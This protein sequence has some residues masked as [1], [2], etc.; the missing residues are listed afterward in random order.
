MESNRG[1]SGCNPGDSIAGQSRL[2]SFGFW[3]FPGI[4]SLPLRS[5]SILLSPKFLLPLLVVA[6]GTYVAIFGFPLD[7]GEAWG[8]IATADPV[9]LGAAVLVHYASY[10]LRGARWRVLMGGS[11]VPVPGFL[12]CGQLILLGWFVNSVGWIRLG[13]PFR[14]HLC[15]REWG[16]SFSWVMGTIVAER[17]LDGLLVSLFLLSAGLL[18]LLSGQWDVGA[19]ALGLSLFLLLVLAMALVLMPLVRWMVRRFLPARGF[20]EFLLSTLLRFRSGFAGGRRR[21]PLTALLGVL[22]WSAE[23][24]RLYLVCQALGTGCWAVCGGSALPRGFAPVSLPNAGRHRGGGGRDGRVGGAY[25]FRDSP[26][27]CCDGIARPGHHH[28]Q[29]GP[30][31]PGVI[32]CTCG[33]P[34]RVQ[35]PVARAGRCRCL[36]ILRSQGSV[37]PGNGRG[38]M[39]VTGV[40]GNAGTSGAMLT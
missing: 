35:A 7:L 34:E 19:G 3:R 14:A 18:L 22:A 36:R 32:E 39:Y 11:P 5:L 31:R 26:G 37:A 20:S 25:I 17:L 4:C 23:V 6:G 1:L 27:G 15:Q 13:D 24:G 8:L 21:F 33:L 9:L 12:Y 28:A 10:F 30:D 38:A 29:R 2:P 16:A 40:N